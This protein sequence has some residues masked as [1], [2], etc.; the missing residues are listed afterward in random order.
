MKIR[1]RFLVILVMLIIFFTDQAFW[2]YY[3]TN[4]DDPLLYKLNYVLVAV[5]SV[6]CLLYY[7]Y[8]PVLLRWWLG[9][10][11]AYIGLLMLEAYQ[12]QGH[13][14]IY[15]HVFMKL[16][17]LLMPPGVYL[18]HRRFGMPHL[19]VLV[20]VL[21]L[22]LMGNLLL[23]HPD[24]LSWS[25]FADNKRGF[26][27]PSAHLFLL[28]VL[29]SLNWYLQRPSFT[30]MGVFFLSMAMVFFLQHR[31]IWACTAVALPVNLLLLRRVPTAVLSWRR[32][33]LLVTIPLLAI[34][35][36]G[37]ATVLD[38]PDVMRRIDESIEDIRNPNKQ[39]TGEW[40]R[41]QR[42][43]YTPFVE[44]RPLMGWRLEGFELPVQFYDPSSNLPMWEDFTGH[45]FH[46]FYLDRMFY[47]GIVGVLLTLTIPIILVYR[48]LR[49]PTPLTPEMVAL[50]SF[51]ST[52]LVYAYSYD[53][54][55]YHYAFL[56]FMLAA[57]AEPVPVMSPVPVP[58]PPL[59]GSATWPPAPLSAHFSA[60]E[61]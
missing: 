6:V 48:R 43:A 13:W 39:G 20:A 11:L 3:T 35:L 26:M 10:T 42:E 19:R 52:F 40:R 44:E 8:L 58:A 59:P 61:A 38:N 50:I 53:W 47:L 28:L 37:L 36:G 27:T 55:F 31:T 34:S 32:L 21:L 9:L 25:A 7:R 51:G 41:L 5:S 33:S 18:L 4:E 56:G 54:S 17:V 30:S 24:S 57:L 1:L 60:Q 29:L 49:Q 15:P 14:F 23:Y 2:E 12:M 16:L 46:S 22:V 45:H